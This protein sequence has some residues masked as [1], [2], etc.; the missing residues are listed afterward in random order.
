MS[1][2]D[3]YG[4]EVTQDDPVPGAAPAGEANP[5]DYMSGETEGVSE[6]TG[7]VYDSEGEP[8]ATPHD[9]AP[10]TDDPTDPA[11]PNAG[12]SATADDQ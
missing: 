10:E 9:V 12:T 1:Q 3:E 6:D 4:A 5:G 11:G 7:T 2:Q 8:E